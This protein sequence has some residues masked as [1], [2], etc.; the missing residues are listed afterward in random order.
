MQVC[1]FYF[2]FSGRGKYFFANGDRYEGEF[3][4]GERDG[5]GI[6]FYTSGGRRSGVWSQDKLVGEVRLQSLSRNFVPLKIQIS[7]NLYFDLDITCWL[8]FLETVKSSAFFLE[9]CGVLPSNWIRQQTHPSS[10]LRSSTT[11]LMER[12]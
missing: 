10:F 1:K 3:D 7:L 11:S 4:N 5:F 6:I 2:Q 8:S 12:C 9:L